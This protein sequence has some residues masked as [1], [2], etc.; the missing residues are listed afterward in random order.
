MTPTDADVVRFQLGRPPRG[1][2]RVAARCTYGYPTVIA[3]QSL[4]PSGEPFPTL[5]W[6]TCPYCTE[7]VGQLESAGHV[8]VWATRLA[9]DPVLAERMREADAAYRS[10][11][12][13]CTR[14]LQ[15]RLRV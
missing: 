3:T 1:I 10:A 8:E 2:W 12:S 9:N 11:P 5:L 7:V 13:V 4:L 6:L 14:T 15:P